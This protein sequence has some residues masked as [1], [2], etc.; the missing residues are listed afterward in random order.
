M[1]ADVNHISVT[2]GNGIKREEYGPVKKA[3]V[4]IGATIADGEDYGVVLDLLTSQAI[5]KVAFMLD[6]PKPETT[7]AVA[8]AAEPAPAGEPPARRKPGPK[9]KDT[10]ASPEPEKEPAA[11]TEGQVAPS[12]T[13][14]GT[15]VAPQA[16]EE[17]TAAPTEADI[18]DKQ[19]QETT[20]AKSTALGGDD[21]H[22]AL[23]KQLILSF[24]N[25][26]DGPPFKVQEIP[27]A[28]RRDYLTKLAAIT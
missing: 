25:R 22:R 12:T 5:A 7:V 9:P 3:E 4:T 16:D 20:S 6:A 10:A 23:I 21:A 28:Q 17:W 19:L 15:S 1:P 11:V 13:Q 2:F 24:S 14:P 27:Q 8:A 26:T 18:S